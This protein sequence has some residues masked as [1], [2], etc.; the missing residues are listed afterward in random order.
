MKGTTSANL[1][2]SEPAQFT[3]VSNFT[4]L[5][6]WK[7][8]HNLVKYVYQITRKFPKTEDYGLTSQ[9]RRAIVSVTSNIAEGFSRN[10]RGDKVQFYT[11]AQGSLTE[12]EDQILVAKDVG[13]LSVE[14]SAKIITRLR[15]T[16]KLISGLIRTARSWGTH[17]N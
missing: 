11:I 3:P 5:K 2:Q 17:A 7:S 4:D 9:L 16:Q 14:D 8:G 13:Y 15:D 1:D 6:A 10:M 12:V